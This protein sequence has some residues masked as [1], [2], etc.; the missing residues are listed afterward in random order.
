[1]ERM[2]HGPDEFYFF[3]VQCFIHGNDMRGCALIGEARLSRFV[4][5]VGKWNATVNE[6]QSV[7]EVL[8]CFVVVMDV[9]LINAVLLF[10]RI[11]NRSIDDFS[12]V[13]CIEFA[14]DHHWPCKSGRVYSHAIA[15]GSYVRLFQG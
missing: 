9:K 10:V 1:M 11:R 7:V 6:Y 14:F 4:F 5:F 8:P 3:L 13:A 2:H 15:K 12:I